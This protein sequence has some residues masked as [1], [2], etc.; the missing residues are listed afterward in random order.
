MKISFIVQTQ[1]QNML[2]V[3]LKTKIT[4]SR[5]FTLLNYKQ[6]FP[7]QNT[8]ATTMLEHAINPGT[9]AIVGHFS[10]C[11]QGDVIGTISLNQ[12]GPKPSVNIHQNWSQSHS[13]AMFDCIKSWTYNAS[14][15]CLFSD[16]WME[17]PGVGFTCLGWTSAFYPGGVPALRHV[18]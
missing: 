14:T 5:I 16:H 18:N 8:I 13:K 9:T 17:R 3:W 12:V 2:Q 7:Y 1:I 4:Y 11:Y 15:M 6:K 10:R